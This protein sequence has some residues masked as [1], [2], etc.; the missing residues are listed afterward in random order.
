MYK[1]W[2]PQER[3]SSI[4]S[5]EFILI[6]LR[7]TAGIH[8]CCTRN[9]CSLLPETDDKV[10]SGANSPGQYFFPK[11]RY[12]WIIAILNCL[13][14]FPLSCNLFREVVFLP[15]CKFILAEWYTLSNKTQWPIHQTSAAVALRFF[16]KRL[17]WGRKRAGE[18]RVG[19]APSE[20]VQW[21]R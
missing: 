2:L 5:L 21:L 19:E 11:H 4:K 20:C 3:Q 10:I 9:L 6:T 16:G 13:M 14:I 17:E 8:E 12:G 18:W 1:L 15:S 7:K